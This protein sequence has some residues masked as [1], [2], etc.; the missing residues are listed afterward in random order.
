[1]SK[2][3]TSEKDTGIQQENIEQ[4]EETALTPTT[5]SS[6][7]ALTLQGS[8]PLFFETY[9]K[10]IDRVIE[11]IPTPAKLQ[12]IIDDL[13]EDIVDNIA[14]IIKKVSGSKK[15]VY[16]DDTRP[17]FPELRLFHG[18]GNDPNRPQN[19]IPGHFYLTSKENCGDSFIG[20]VLAIFEGRT[21]WPDNESG[22]EQRM[23]ICQ[24]MDRKIGST[25]GDC[26]TCP[27]KPWSDG[28][29]QQ[30]GDDVVAFM[31]VKD[32]NEIV[33][34]RFSKTS[35][36]AGKRLVRF[37]KRSV[38][39]WSRWYKITS[40]ERISKNN[41]NIRWYIM[42]VSP[43]NDESVP[44]AIGPFCDAMCSL[45]EA[46]AIL[47]NIADVYRR[48]QEVLEE[49]DSTEVTGGSAKPLTPD[50]VKDA[51]YGNFD[52]IPEDNK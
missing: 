12:G 33:K 29:K 17:D 22:D 27:H 23:P 32:L 42:E 36:G 1:M 25:Y 26:N 28:K 31:L 51:D 49:Q 35:E 3:T 45:L 2:K 47:P 44:E 18:T 13:P 38:M 4:A 50:D 10:T 21:M 46:T 7:L 9:Q 37:V 39:P 40:D 48:A 8:P 43:V 34:V 41:K 16:T 52:N 15:G 19:M 6:P 14:E 24:S 5:S 11:E 30:C 20:T